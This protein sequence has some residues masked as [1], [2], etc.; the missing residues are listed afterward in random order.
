[1]APPYLSSS[2]D[3]NGRAAL[4]CLVVAAAGCNTVPRTL[5]GPAA[6]PAP[7][8]PASL[9]GFDAK[10]NPEYQTYKMQKARIVQ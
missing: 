1:M 2:V 10:K 3:T 5:T 6:L 4:G 8:L 9:P 7:T